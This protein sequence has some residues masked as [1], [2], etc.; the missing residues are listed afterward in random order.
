MAELR[1][2]PQWSQLSLKSLSSKREAAARLNSR[3]KASAGT[4]R[5]HRKVWP[6]SHE[7]GALNARGG[8]TESAEDEERVTGSRPG[9]TGNFRVLGRRR[10]NANLLSVGDPRN[11]CAISS[12]RHQ[13]EAADCEAWRKYKQVCFLPAPSPPPPR[14]MLYFFIFSS[15]FFPKSYKCSRSELQSKQPGSARRKVSDTGRKVSR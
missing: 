2:H 10:R 1:A 11:V 14:G 9:R 15:F 5:P 13:C 8:E 6:L 4:P 12:G 3:G 7:R